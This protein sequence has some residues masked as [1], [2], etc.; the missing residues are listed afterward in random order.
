[1]LVLVQID[2]LGGTT[3]C[4]AGNFRT[5]Q[6]FAILRIGWMQQKFPTMVYYQKHDDQT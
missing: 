2:V 1:M 4:I 3:Y 5:V 6:N